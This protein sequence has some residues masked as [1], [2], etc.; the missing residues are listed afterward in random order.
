MSHT[1]HS[2]LSM[3]QSVRVRAKY[4][5]NLSRLCCAHIQR[6]SQLLVSFSGSKF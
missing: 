5:Q 6:F 4:F 2:A 3:Y 1:G